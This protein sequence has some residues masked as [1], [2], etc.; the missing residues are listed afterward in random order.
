MS[1]A[2]A[3]PAVASGITFWGRVG[4]PET[5]DALA[6]LRSHRYAADK[7]RDLMRDGPMGEELDRLARGLGGFWPLVDPKCPDLPRLVPR[8]E[9][10]P[11]E[12]LRDL[13]AMTPGL[14]RSPLLLTP[15]G[16]LAGFRER[17]WREFLDIGKGRS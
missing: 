3:V 13:L 17:Q 9:A 5:N 1:H 2:P 14:L 15:R 12:A 10:T 16:T 7:V 11:P 4:A 6:F 8:G